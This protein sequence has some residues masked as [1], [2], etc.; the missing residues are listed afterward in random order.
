MDVDYVSNSWSDMEL[1]Q[2]AQ[3]VERYR[4]DTHW[5][6]WSDHRE[7]RRSEAVVRQRPEVDS[8]LKVGKGVV[9]F[10]RWIENESRQYNL[11]GFIGMN[12]QMFF[13]IIR[14]NS[15]KP[16]TLGPELR[17]AI[18]LPND[19]NGAVTAIARFVDFI[20]KENERVQN[21]RKRA[22]IGS[23]PYFLSYFWNVLQ[24]G[25][26]PIYFPSAVSALYTANVK[27]LWE[28][29]ELDERYATFFELMDKVRRDLSMAGGQSD[30]FTEAE[31]FLF[32][33]SERQSEPAQNAQEQTPQTLETQMADD[34]ELPSHHTEIQWML[35]KMGKKMGYKVHVARNDLGKVW[36]GDR[37]ENLG[38]DAL[39]LPGFTD[40]DRKV[41]E[42]IDVV[43][44]KA[45]KITHLFEVES[46]TTIFSGLLR[47]S[48]LLSLQ[49]TLR[50]TMTIVAPEERHAEAQR[51]IDRPTFRVLCEQEPGRKFL[52]RSF[53]DVKDQFKLEE[54][55]RVIH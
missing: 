12:G 13:N 10:S 46:T 27:D 1:P 22:A 36:R 7:I 32:W 49:P 48:D 51:I 17:A 30:N 43:W 3:L 6:A 52:F 26:F 40:A 5:K 35:A 29:D 2:L 34:G 53:D 21:P 55:G 33:V 24:P 44:F 4:K 16:E 50:P 47:M 42:L 18:N 39:D 31:N 11:W 19:K 20:R 28:I 9:D 23:I 54:S 41:I 8:F 15:S 38:G 37:L 14:N 45:N 25:K